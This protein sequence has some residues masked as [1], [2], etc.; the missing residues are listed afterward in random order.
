MTSVEKQP[1]NLSLRLIFPVTT[2][3]V[4]LQIF[5][6]L[7]DVNWEIDHQSH[8]VGE[9]SH[10]GE[11]TACH[12]INKTTVWLDETLYGG[13]IDLFVAALLNISFV[14][15]FTNKNE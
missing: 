2:M 9:P 7:A 11:S 15:T 8:I 14:A 1:K 13:S 5:G 6:A 12:C 3:W 10:L 4:N